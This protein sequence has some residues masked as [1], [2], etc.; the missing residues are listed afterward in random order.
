MTRP[1]PT[2][3]AAEPDGR[4]DAQ[5]W[6]LCGVLVLGA[7]TTLLDGTIVNVAIDALSHE[8]DSTIDTIQ[9]TV[10]GY[11]LALSIVVPLSGWAME[12]FGAKRMW[13]AAQA[14][15]LIGSVLSGIAWSVESLVLFR[16]VQGLGGGMVM[17]MA[18]AMLARA[19]GP[20]RLGRVMAVVSVPAMLAPIIGPVI[21][22]VFVDEL[23]WRWIFFVNIPIGLAAIVL[24]WIKL[25]AD[26]PAKDARLDLLGL[27]LL[28][29]GL[30]LLLYGAAE[31]GSEGFTGNG[32]LPYT[33]AGVLLL[34]GFA[35]HAL[36]TT[37]TP[38]IDLRLLKDRGYSAAVLTQF[39]LNSA[40]FGAMFLLPLYFQ[41]DRGD[42]VLQAGLMLAPQGVGYVIAMAV[43]GK[44][45]DKMGPGVLALAGVVVTL[46][47]TLPFALIDQNS[48]Q[49]LLAAA[50]VARGI[51]VGVVTLPS[52]A[53]AYRSL[54]P[55]AMPRASSAMNIFQRLG[56]SVGTAV[57]A[58]VLQNAVTAGKAD[59]APL[60]ESFSASFWWVFAFTALTLLPVLF[61]PRAVP[62]APAA[63]AGRDASAKEPATA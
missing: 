5:L 24:A 6:W 34:T 20:G 42:T 35:T 43:V 40:V 55:A 47:G 26:R 19:A 1:T 9:W 61:L 7:V 13:L 59:G 36:R 22:G 28:S 8:F 45:T 57:V 46:L 60:A 53:A 62:A 49:G 33:V 21:G 41:M 32:S 15:F 38:L 44:A 23:N 18:Q 58:V 12:R 63:A 14:L 4:I 48:D 56:G 39:A 37:R 11:L 29:P 10:T 17:P 16:V 2:P 51:G 25:P 54:A 27:L 52:L 30:A 50:M 31:S 3:P